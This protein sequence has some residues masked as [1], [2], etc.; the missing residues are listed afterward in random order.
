MILKFIQFVTDNC[1]M[2]CRNSAKQTK[3]F[4]AFSKAVIVKLISKK[5]SVWLKEHQEHVQN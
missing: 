5:S 1:S 4:K 3:H 2:L